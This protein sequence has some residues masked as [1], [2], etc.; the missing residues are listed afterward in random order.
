MR[1]DQIL[2]NFSWSLTT[3]AFFLRD[4]AVV[5]VPCYYRVLHFQS[6][7]EKTVIFE[8]LPGRPPVILDRQIIE[9][10]IEGEDGIWRTFDTMPRVGTLFGTVYEFARRDT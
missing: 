6:L 4:N 7:E 8:G 1:L 10:A 9:N 2:P 3:S 5:I